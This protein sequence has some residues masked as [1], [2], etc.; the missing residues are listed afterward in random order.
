MA[1]TFMFV[2]EEQSKLPTLN[3][4]PK[5]DKRPFKS[6]LIAYPCSCITTELSIILTSC[7]TVIKNYVIKYCET[8]HDRNG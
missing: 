6:R 4:L 8:V 1:A 3:W 2:D 7:L 5:L